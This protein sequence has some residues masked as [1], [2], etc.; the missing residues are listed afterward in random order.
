MAIS[1]RTPKMA[2]NRKQQNQQD[3]DGQADDPLP[4]S[5]HG[6]ILSGGR[7]IG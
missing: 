4:V 6:S 2:H 7:D 5:F 3:H 1:S